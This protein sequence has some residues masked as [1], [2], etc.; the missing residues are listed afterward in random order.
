MSHDQEEVRGRDRSF[1]ALSRKPTGLWK[2]TMEAIWPEQTL[3]GSV[4][5]EL[6]EVVGIR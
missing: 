2:E 6:R 3:L 1:R 4:V 5:G